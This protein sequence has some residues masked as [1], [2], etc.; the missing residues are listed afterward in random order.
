MLNTFCRWFKFHCR[1]FSFTHFT[2]WRETRGHF[3]RTIASRE[4]CGYYCSLSEEC[5][6]G[7]LLLK[8]TWRANASVVGTLLWP[9]LSVQLPRSADSCIQIFEGSSAIMLL[10]SLTF[11]WMELSTC[12]ELWLFAQLCTNCI[13][14]AQSCRLCSCSGSFFLCF[15][16]SFWFLI[17]IQVV[18]TGQKNG[19][20]WTQGLCAVGAWPGLSK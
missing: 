8:F 5:A 15:C 20:M 2:G 14:G 3:Q 10:R 7:V 19:M 4:Q 13:R 11:V 9:T 12:G 16:F 1:Q 6:F 17:R 18:T